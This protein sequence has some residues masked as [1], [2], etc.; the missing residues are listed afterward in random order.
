VTDKKKGGYFRSSLSL[1][2][3]IGYGTP[4]FYLFLFFLGTQLGT[5]LLPFFFIPIISYPFQ[6]GLFSFFLVAISLF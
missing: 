1:L 3:T 5:F 2:G 4:S 6:Q